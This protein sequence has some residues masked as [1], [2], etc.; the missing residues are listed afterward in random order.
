MLIVVLILNARSV[1]AQVPNNGS[2]SAYLALLQMAYRTLVPMQYGIW[3][4]IEQ[5]RFHSYPT[6]KEIDML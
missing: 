6:E 4:S 2:G 1:E 3:R 5:N